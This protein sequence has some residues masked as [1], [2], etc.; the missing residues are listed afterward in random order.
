MFPMSPE[1]LAR[2]VMHDQDQQRQR[3]ARERMAAAVSGGHATRASRARS[4]GSS[5]AHQVWMMARRLA[6]PF[7][8]RH[9]VVPHHPAH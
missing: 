3:V 8:S 6:R 9:V 4:A 7:R 2:Q 1:D 5:G